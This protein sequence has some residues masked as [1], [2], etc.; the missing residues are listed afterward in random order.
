[1]ARRNP[2][3]CRW[4][5][6]LRAFRIRIGLFNHPFGGA[7]FLPQYFIQKYEVKI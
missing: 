3:T 5:P 7:G 1:M 6:S 2:T 4:I